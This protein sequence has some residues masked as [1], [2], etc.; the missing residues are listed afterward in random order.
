[1]KVLFTSSAGVWLWLWPSRW[2]HGFCSPLPGVFGAAEV[3]LMKFMQSFFI[4]ISKTFHFSPFTVLQ[5]VRDTITLFINNKNNKTVASTLNCNN[6]GFNFLEALCF[7]Q[8]CRQIV[9][10]LLEQRPH[11]FFLLLTVMAPCAADSHSSSS[12]QE[13]SLP[14]QANK[15]IF[16]HRSS[17]VPNFPEW[18]YGIF[19]LFLSQRFLPVFPHIYMLLLSLW[20][21]DSLKMFTSV[22]IVNFLSHINVQ[23]VKEE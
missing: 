13:I 1:M 18:F 3:S 23:R 11:L 17:S 12:C 7:V 15:H 9:I 14:I 21:G 22:H 2:L 20:G 16:T 4:F 6:Q 5:P 8:F 19:S 10:Y